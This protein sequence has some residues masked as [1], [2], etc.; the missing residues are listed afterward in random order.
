MDPEP[1]H[2][3]RE[4]FAR[5]TVLL[6]GEIG[7]ALAERVTAQLLALDAASA[8]PIRLFVCSPGGH[9]E[10]GDT[11]FDVIRFVRAEVT[12]I[13]S[14]WV[15]SAGALVFCAC[16]RERRVALPNTRFLLHEP[17]GGVGGSASDIEVEAGQLLAMRA[18][19]H[20]IFAEATGRSVEQIAHDTRRDHWM[21]AEEAVAYGLV[22]RVVGRESDLSDRREAPQS[23]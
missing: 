8:D 12:A 16:A 4:L 15:A 10:S 6:F 19:L 22:G 1:P 3:T 11:I 23:G 21:T 14:G 9:V 13:G 18:R 5:R 20:R 17:R 7:P 2:V